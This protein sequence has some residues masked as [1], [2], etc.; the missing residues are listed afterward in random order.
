MKRFLNAIVLIPWLLFAVIV[1]AAP[2]RVEVAGQWLELSQ[3]GLAQ[4]LR[5][6]YYLGGFYL[7]S[8]L[9]DIHSASAVAP[10]RMS[11]IVLTNRMSA[12]EFQRHW[13]ERIA[14]N[15]A[16]NEWQPH[17]ESILRFA[18]SIKDTLQRGDR[19]DIDKFKNTVRISL[20]GSEL[21]TLDDNGFFTL[22]LN[23]WLGENPPTQ[24]F[25]RAM[26]G[27]A[28][29]EERQLWLADWQQLQPVQRE[30]V[31][32]RKALPVV[33][34]AEKPVAKPEPNVAA[35]KA[36]TTPVSKP[37]SKPVA[38]PEPTVAPKVETTTAAT[39]VVVAQ[40]EPEVKSV[41]TAEPQAVPS[42]ADQV[43]EQAASNLAS[44][45]NESAPVQAET[46]ELD[47][48]LLLGE[49]KRTVLTHIRRHLEYP[50]RAWRLGLTGEGVIR[51]QVAS[52]GSVSDA[53]IIESTGQKLLDRSMNEMVER[54]M[55]LPKPESG[56]PAFTL[57]IPV[58]FAR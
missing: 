52:D 2:N 11:F 8:G 54:A 49:Y 13:K 19:V 36:V 22:L 55:P 42:F 58:A 34:S 50:S 17:G 51:I 6:D 29:A 37:V 1:Q 24:A 15:N 57:D 56:M 20:N 4:E 48:D 45:V 14:L 23:C 46:I 5:S 31:S 33:A 27:E 3:V 47:T 32:L 21:I 7:A 9:N 40:R 16:R 30:L 39:E 44:M 25:R 26:N 12:R 53:E 41:P 43:A 10:V 35:N 38:K 18:G 28:A